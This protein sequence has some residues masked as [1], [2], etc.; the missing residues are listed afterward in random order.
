MT[1]TQLSNALTI[2]MSHLWSFPFS[3]ES[4]ATIACTG[5]LRNNSKTLV[6]M[7]EGSFL[8][9]LRT[10][11]QP[12]NLLKGAFLNNTQL[13]I[14]SDQITKISP[15]IYNIT[16]NNSSVAI[17]AT[18]TS[19]IINKVQIDINTI[20]TA[21]ATTPANTVYA[22]WVIFDTD[23]NSLLQQTSSFQTS[24]VTLVGQQLMNCSNE[25]SGEIYAPDQYSWDGICEG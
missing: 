6:T 1:K 17:D 21:P 12:F 4:N 11:I 7:I 10:A 23:A 3:V 18:N 24:L 5:S 22:N 9:N 19:A 2:T 20:K 15:Y 25:M 13:Q 16:N 8:L 14:V